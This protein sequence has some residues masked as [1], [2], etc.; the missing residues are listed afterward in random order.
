MQCVG[1]LG[2]HNTTG[3]TRLLAATILDKLTWERVYKG[4]GPAEKMIDQF[5]VYPS[6]YFRAH[7]ILGMG[8]LNTV[9]W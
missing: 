1:A 8:T 4:F 9:P 7:S 3:T 5:K 6:I 2:P